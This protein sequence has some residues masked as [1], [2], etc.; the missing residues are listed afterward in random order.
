[1]EADILPSLPNPLPSQGK[2]TRKRLMSELHITVTG[3][4]SVH[5]GSL[6]N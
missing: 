1:M 3:I 5:G 6:N 4:Q 2:M